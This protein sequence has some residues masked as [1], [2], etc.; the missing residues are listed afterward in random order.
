MASI[1]KRPN[2]S[3]EIRYTDANSKRCSMYPGKLTRKAADDLGRK[4]DH[5]VTR[6][7]TG[8]EP[9]RPVAEWIAALPDKLHSKLSKAGLVPARKAAE[10]AP[11]PVLLPTL[12]EWTDSYL[13]KHAGK[14]GTIRQ[15]EVTQQTLLKHFGKGRRIDT[16][17]AGDAEDFRNWMQTNGNATKDY[18][19]GLAVN[20]IRR[21][22]G[23]SK[24]FFA[25]AVRHKLLTENPFAGE[26][27]SVS[28]NAD[29][30]FL[31][32]AEWIERCIRVAPCEDWRI[33]LAFARYAGM[34]S[35]ECRM[36]RWEDIDL[37]NN[38][39]IIRSNKTPPVRSCPIFPELRQHLLR[40]REMA[41]AGAEYVQTRYRPDDNIQTTLAKIVT[42][43]GLVP[44]PKLMQNM[45][46]TRETELM[47]HYPAK[48]VTSWLGNSPSIANRHYLMAM[49]SSFDRAV[50]EGAKLAG[51]TSG[52]GVPK[53]APQKTPHKV[54]QTL[55][56]KGGNSETRNKPASSESEKT[57]ENSWICL[58]S[59]LAGLP[60]RVPPVGQQ[61]TK[62]NIGQ[63]G[64]GLESTTQSTTPAAMVAACMSQHLDQQLLHELLQELA[65]YVSTRPPRLKGTSRP[66]V[67]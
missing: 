36:Q 60:L 21:R 38:R 31:V 37:A 2:G 50:I 44:W 51:V 12:Q 33:I 29:R 55:T 49:Q 4:I 14:H 19:C 41:P 35:H 65:V 62:E 18:S 42:R 39:M 58:V 8:D 9:D 47:A 17:T 28:G 7:I 53:S 63:T 40:A 34:R 45:R 32:P 6:Q 66:R 15:L 22:I 56:D 64:A 59:A 52:S 48:D 10:P 27:S 13:K 11:E 26:K 20:T 43:A 3:Y 25:A 30:M 5:L 67:S 23:R 61:L 54:P 46:A 24:Q 16:I 57:Q 1:I